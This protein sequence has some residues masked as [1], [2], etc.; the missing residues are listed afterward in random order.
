[1]RNLFGIYFQQIFQIFLQKSSYVHK[2][3]IKSQENLLIFSRN[4]PNTF[5][6]YFSNSLFHTYF[7]YTC[8]KLPPVYFVLFSN[9]FK[10]FQ[11]ISLSKLSRLFYIK[12]LQIIFYQTLYT[13]FSKISSEVFVI[14][15][16]FPQILTEFHHF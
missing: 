3:F 15:S 12:I 6:M 14:L 5:P 16:N 10:F 4:S 11:Q 1:M 13:N 9:Y 2:F 7:L 8:L